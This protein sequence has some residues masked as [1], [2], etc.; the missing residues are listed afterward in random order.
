MP[1]GSIGIG[2]TRRQLIQ[3]VSI[4][5][6]V[7]SLVVLILRFVSKHCVQRRVSIDDWFML[8]AWEPA[9]A[10]IK[11]SVLLYYQRLFRDYKTLKR[12]SWC[13]MF[14]IVV[15]AFVLTMLVVFQCRPFHIVLI[16]HNQRINPGHWKCLDVVRLVYAAAPLQ[17]ITDFAVI[18]LPMPILSGLQLPR[19]QKAMLMLIF[20]AGGFVAVLQ[21]I[22]AYYF[23]I[24]SQAP[25]FAWPDTISFLWAEITVFVGVLAA[26][27]PM[28]KP[29]IRYLPW[30]CGCMMDG[31]KSVG[32]D[33]SEDTRRVR[34]ASTQPV[35]HDIQY[36][37]PDR[38]EVMPEM[39]EVLAMPPTAFG[40]SNTSTISSFAGSGISSGI[41][42][43][44]RPERAELAVDVL[45]SMQEE[46]EEDMNPHNRGSVGSLGDSTTVQDSAP[47]PLRDEEKRWLETHP[48][49]KVWPLLMLMG[50]PF[51][52]WGMSHGLINVMFKKFEAIRGMDEHEAIGMTVAYWGMYAVTP[53]T[54]GGYLLR[55]YGFRM[56][57]A[58]G[59]FIYSVGCMC[60]WPSAAQH[61]YPGIV[62][63]VTVVGVGCST[64]EVAANPFVAL[65]G[66]PEYAEIRL[67]ILQGV[68]AIGGLVPLL[69]QTPLFYASKDSLS[70]YILR[71]IQWTFLACSFAAFLLAGI[72]CCI[73]LPEFRDPVPEFRQSSK[74]LFATNFAPA[75]ILALF[76]LMLYVGSQEIFAYFDRNMLVDGLQ[77]SNTNGLA[78]KKIGWA[79]L[80]FGRFLSAFLLC[81][82]RPSFL[83]LVFTLGLVVTAAVTMT[84]HIQLANA[85]FML[86]QF[87]QST[88]WPTIFCLALRGTGKDVVTASS[89]LVAMTVGAVFLSPSFNGI[90]D[91]RGPKIAVGLT[92]ATFSVMVAYPVVL[93]LSGRER[94]RV[95]RKPV[96]VVREKRAS[97]VGSFS[98]VERVGSGSTL[99][100]GGREVWQ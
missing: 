55:H 89:Y 72:F 65:Y 10:L 67:N 86:N 31:Y 42:S 95:R 38:M 98:H 81:F 22:R 93:A 20:G 70:W 28:L 41:S 51:F 13:I 35:L 61:S 21:V 24:A 39:Q 37:G 15:G 56:T 66:P 79:M 16:A 4:A 23:Q 6:G 8:G 30:R 43:V 17:I 87:F 27:T 3:G 45:R 47:P 90:C 91:I 50:G 84:T 63:S 11:V 94:E 82:I 7:L 74:R 32:P 40:A 25:D 62:V 5:L 69:I 44:T 36:A 34:R 19:K 26:S 77:N 48:G 14:V 88:I 33:A 49:T 2:S 52:M 76:T 100:N 60:Y 64:M 71:D 78:F 97:G 54:W 18:L 83:L 92:V 1:P 57:L 85:A 9:F 29:L 12:L 75:F 73:H 68:Q 80:T 46:D 96:V 59:L 53:L 99:E 58:I